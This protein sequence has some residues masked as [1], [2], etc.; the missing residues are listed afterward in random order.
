MSAGPKR[1]LFLGVRLLSGLFRGLGV[2]SFGLPPRFGPSL[3]SPHYFCITKA[4]S[5]CGKH[6]L[7]LYALE[8][9]SFRFSLFFL[10]L[11]FL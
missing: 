5:I 10:S 6:L 2:L 8:G 3:F 4:I 9:P 1:G 7:E 11:L